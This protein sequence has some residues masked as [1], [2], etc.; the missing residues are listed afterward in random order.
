MNRAEIKAGALAALNRQD[1]ANR[2]DGWLASALTKINTRLR[3]NDMLTRVVRDIDA[4]NF[5]GPAGFIQAESIELN[6][7]PASGQVAG[8]TRGPL[9]YVPA[10]Q[11]ASTLERRAR[12]GFGYDRRD[13]R[14]YFYTIRGTNHIEI[15][16]WRSAGP[17]QIEMWYFK[18]VEV[19][20]SDTG[21]NWLFTN[22]PQMVIDAM[23]IYGHR[24]LFEYQE[25]AGYEVAIDAKINEL[26]EAY[27][28]SKASAGP[29]VAPSPR[30]MGGRRS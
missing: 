25:S 2:A 16:P 26:N 8:A 29:L 27:L 21:T 5:L 13:L 3:V 4:P 22:D 10:D 19:P 24:A 15:L 7:G 6:S 18:R 1:M 30:K 12:E 9:R 20:T 14:P 23:L 17:F 28:M 11:I